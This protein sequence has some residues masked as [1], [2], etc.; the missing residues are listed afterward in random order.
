[1]LKTERLIDLGPQRSLFRLEAGSGTPI[2]LM[3]GAFTTHVDWLEA[4]LAA[5]AERGR[6]IAV[7]RPGHGRSARRRFDAHPAAQAAQIREGLANLEGRPRLIVGHSMG[8]LAALAYAAAWP[9]EVAGL[10]L[11]GPITRPE[12]RPLE[13]LILAPR[14]TPVAGPWMAELARPWFD[15]GLVRLVQAAMFWPAPPPQGW[16]DRYP[17]GAVRPAAGTVAE[18]EDA[19]AVAPG[20]PPVDLG[21]IRAPVRIVAGEQDIVVD[22]RRHAM[23]LGR[24]LPQSETLILPGVG[25]M[26]HHLALPEVMRAF[27]AMTQPAMA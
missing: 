2:V 3:H 26:P 10:L 18:G 19:L 14:A 9:E 22:R 15:A 12:F 8:G 21:L 6:A 25:H 4:P 20:S 24:M 16:L 1:M 27:D 13:H 17:H 11:L 5:F 7:D 23:A